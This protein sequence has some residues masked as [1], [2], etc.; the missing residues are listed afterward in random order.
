ML[1]ICVAFLIWQYFKT[2]CEINLR[3]C[4]CIMQEWTGSIQDADMTTS[5]RIGV[6]PIKQSLHFKSVY[7]SQMRFQ[8]V[9]NISSFNL[10]QCFVKSAC[11]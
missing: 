8:F 2:G 6:V 4:V 9:P 11:Q 1:L 7:I 5:Y 3:E 10:K